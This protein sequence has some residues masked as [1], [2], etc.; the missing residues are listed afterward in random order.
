[1]QAPITGEKPGLSTP[2]KSGVQA[3]FDQPQGRTVTWI[4]GNAAIDL[5]KLDLSQIV[6]KHYPVQRTDNKK[7]K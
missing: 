1:M 5:A 3:C 4:H 2:R 6:R 7:N